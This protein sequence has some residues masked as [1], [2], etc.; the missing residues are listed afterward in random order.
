MFDLCDPR[1]ACELS[2]THIH[3][4]RRLVHQSTGEP[5]EELW[6]SIVNEEDIVLRGRCVQTRTRELAAQAIRSV[7]PDAG[8]LNRIEV[9][10]E[11]D[12]GTTFR[13][14]PA[15]PDHTRRQSA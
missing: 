12:P 5:I 11:Q 2:E 6:I 8:I 3:D 4:L 1:E 9:V 7:A 15:S 10:A 13:R 14:L